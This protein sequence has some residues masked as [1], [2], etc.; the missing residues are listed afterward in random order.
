ML[1]ELFGWIIGAIILPVIVWL[2][3]T[4]AALKKSEPDTP[5]H[6]RNKIA[7]YIFLAAAFLIVEELIRRTIKE[8]FDSI[9]LELLLLVIFLG[10]PLTALSIFIP[11]LICYKRCPKDSPERERYKRAF[12]VSGVCAAILTAAFVALLIMAF[13][14][15]M[16]M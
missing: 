7:L 1:E 6:R 9:A 3:R 14:G 2:A 11:A 5:A 16:H 8:G 12:L 10:L 15:L 4:A 13:I